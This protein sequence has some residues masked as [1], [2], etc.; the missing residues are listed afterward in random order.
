MKWKLS[1]S[2]EYGYEW[3]LSRLNGR[4]FEWVQFAGA[5]ARENAIAMAEATGGYEEVGI[6]E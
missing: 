3:Q 2:P 4:A 1:P 5:S 6:G